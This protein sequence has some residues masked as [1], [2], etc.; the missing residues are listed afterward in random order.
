MASSTLAVKTPAGIQMELGNGD[1]TFRTGPLT[2]VPGFPGGIAS[3]A[4][5]N[6]DGI[7]DLFAA[8]GGS[9][10]VFSLT[11]KG[12][13]GFAVTTAGLAPFVPG[14]VEAVKETP[15]GLDSAVALDE[16][17]ASGTA[18]NRDLPPGPGRRRLQR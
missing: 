12:D 18:P 2:T 1:G 16:F 8:D 5:I 3:L 15:N 11:G 6:G 17:N 7:P 4:N 10:Q 13:G 14:T 9:Q